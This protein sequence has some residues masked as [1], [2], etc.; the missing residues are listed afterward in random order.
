MSLENLKIFKKPQ[1]SI[2]LALKKVHYDLLI[3]AQG[4]HIKI[5][6]IFFHK[7]S[8]FFFLKISNRKYGGEF[9]Y[10]FYS[11]FKYQIFAF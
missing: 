3:S 1:E 6:L 7:I 5:E 9:K 4:G 11:N 8:H 2:F 10:T